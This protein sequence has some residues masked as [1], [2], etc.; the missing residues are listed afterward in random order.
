MVLGA[1][2]GMPEMSPPEMLSSMIGISIL[3]GWVI[4]FIIGITFAAGYV[5]V[6]NG[7]LKKIKNKIIKGAVYG[8]IAFIIAQIAFPLMGVIFGEANMPEPEGSMALLMIG[9]VVGHIVF[10]I[11]VALMVKPIIIISK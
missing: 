3:G 11:V 10:G 8:V 2:M 4:H 9:S 5:F 1:M 6:F 7:L